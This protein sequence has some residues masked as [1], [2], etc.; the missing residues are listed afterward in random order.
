MSGYTG[1]EMRTR[2][3]LESGTN[4]IQKPFT[5]DSLIQKVLEVLNSTN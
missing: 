2:G 3:V 1:E 4:F 5:P